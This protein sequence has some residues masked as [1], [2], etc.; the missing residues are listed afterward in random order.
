MC[1]RDSGRISSNSDE[2]DTQRQLNL[3]LFLGALGRVRHNA[4]EP[5][6]VSKM[7]NG[8][9]VGGIREGASTRLAP[10]ANS[11]LVIS[12]FTVVMGEDFG[13]IFDEFG[14]TIL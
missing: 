6:G 11:R 12:R 2:R 3:D 13:L 8:F 1:I 14:K 7:T 4:Q 5:Q 10:P 9:H